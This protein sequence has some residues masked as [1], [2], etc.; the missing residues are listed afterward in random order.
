MQLKLIKERLSFFLSKIYVFF[1]SNLTNKLQFELIIGF[2]D[3]WKYLPAIWELKT[4]QTC[5]TFSGFFCDL[6]FERNRIDTKRFWINICKNGFQSQQRNYFSCGDIS[7]RRRNHFITGFKTQSH[8]CNL[9]GIGSIGTGNNLLN[10]FRSTT[11]SSS[12]MR[13]T[14]SSTCRR[15]RRAMI[16]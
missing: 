10:A 9:N 6:L 16:C 11:T 14:P 8:E 13:L 2:K 15:R 3:V 5:S 1:V 12:S 4:F 7:K